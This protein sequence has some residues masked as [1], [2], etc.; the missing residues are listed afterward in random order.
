MFASTVEVFLNE[1]DHKICN[2]KTL[3]QG[4]FHHGNPTR[5][6]L[7]AVFFGFVTWAALQ[8]NWLSVIHMVI[9][10]TSSNSYQKNSMLGLVLGTLEELLGQKILRKMPL[11]L[12]KN[13]KS[14]WISNGFFK[15]KNQQNFQTFF[16]YS[17]EPK[18]KNLFQSL[19]C[20]NDVSGAIII[21]SWRVIYF[22]RNSV[23]PDTWITAI[24]GIA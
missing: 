11:F 5:V 22:S 4:Q 9:Y 16:H 19:N 7:S 15:Q 8:I 6:V 3:S 21:L 10:S 20:K 2:I 14:D 24:Y 12:V 18:Q 23:P 17:F 1:K 13:K